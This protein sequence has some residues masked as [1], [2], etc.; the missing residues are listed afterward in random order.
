MW[1]ERARKRRRDAGSRCGVCR[2]PRGV[3]TRREWEGGEGIEGWGDTCG[4]ECE[5]GV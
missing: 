3:S 4:G 5:C 2:T 1:V